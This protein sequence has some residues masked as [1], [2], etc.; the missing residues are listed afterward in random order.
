MSAR[1]LYE[2]QYIKRKEKE[3]KEQLDGEKKRLL[4]RKAEI[5]EELKNIK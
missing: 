4:K 5:E 3:M 2:E 1:G